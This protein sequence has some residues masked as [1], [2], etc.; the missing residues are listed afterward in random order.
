MTG[1][2]T[3]QLMKIAADTLS[4]MFIN[5][6]SVCFQLIRLLGKQVLYGDGSMVEGNL[7]RKNA[8]KRKIHSV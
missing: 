8:C 7:K 4:T 2:I 6:L 5:K 1:G 3:Q